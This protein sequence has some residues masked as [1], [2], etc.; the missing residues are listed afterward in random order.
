[1]QLCRIVQCSDVELHVSFI[2][3]TITYIISAVWGI[4]FSLLGTKLGCII[5]CWI[6]EDRRPG[7]GVIQT[8]GVR[9][10]EHYHQSICRETLPSA[11]CCHIWCNVEAALQSYL[12]YREYL[13]LDNP[14]FTRFTDIVFSSV[15]LPFF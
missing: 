4:F 9:F 5:G 10:T 6:C 8:Y 7:V 1:M 15:C 2:I 12:R 13:H 3:C 11:I 14:L